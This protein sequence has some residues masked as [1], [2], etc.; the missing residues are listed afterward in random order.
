[1][2]NLLIERLYR[3]LR[4]FTPSV[5][6]ERD[7]SGGL[8][9]ERIETSRCVCDLKEERFVTQS[10]SNDSEVVLEAEKDLHF[11]GCCRVL[12][13]DMP[14]SDNS[15]VF[16]DENP[17]LKRVKQDHCTDQFRQLFS[18]LIDFVIDSANEVVEISLRFVD[19]DNDI[20]NTAYNDCIMLSAEARYVLLVCWDHVS[21]DAY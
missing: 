20:S 4:G 5:C 16:D 12:T 15:A 10:Y 6:T 1:M 3:C 14:S 2:R 17:T 18:A 13:V 9:T 8:S 7:S 19:Q 11:T 21:R